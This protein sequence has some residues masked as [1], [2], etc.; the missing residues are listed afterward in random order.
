LLK[1]DPDLLT[2][3]IEGF[4]T[5]EEYKDDL[6]YKSNKDMPWVHEKPWTNYRALNEPTPVNI[7]ANLSIIKLDV[8]CGLLMAG[9][10]MDTIIDG[11]CLKLT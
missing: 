4:K 6:I 11:T 1:I 7:V 9:E 5:Y 10:K 2:K 3:D 8:R